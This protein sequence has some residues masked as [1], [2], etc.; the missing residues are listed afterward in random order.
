MA[1][2][3]GQ[4]EAL[5]R[6]TLPAIPT[7]YCLANPD[8]GVTSGAFALPGGLAYIDYSTTLAES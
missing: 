2:Q 4:V 1:T 7:V 3:Y 5:R 8:G 6:V